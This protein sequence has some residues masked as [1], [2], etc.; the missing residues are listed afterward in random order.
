MV[1]ENSNGFMTETLILISKKTYITHALLI[2]IGK[3]M[4]ISPNAIVEITQ[5]IYQCHN[6]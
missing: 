2:C 5:T 1:E 3:K 4:L 6:Q